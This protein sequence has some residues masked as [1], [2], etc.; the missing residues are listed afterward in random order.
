MFDHLYIKWRNLRYY[1]LHRW[2]WRSHLYP[3]RGYQK[4]QYYDTD[5]KLLLTVFSML[6]DYVENEV[7]HLSRISL[8]SSPH[9]DIEA[10]RRATWW[11]RWKNRDR[12]TRL[13]ALAHLE[14]EIGLGL[15]SP[16]QSLAAREIRDVYLW[17]KD[18]R[19]KRLD[20]HVLIPNPADHELYFKVVEEQRDEDDEML[21]RV[22]RARHSMWT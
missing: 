17:Y 12:W 4:G 8:Y 18:I 5:E 16:Q 15:Q 1:V 20:P 22:I 19:P 14:W 10:Y 6:V 11:D 13:L 9:P 3:I 2:V 21:C 7:A